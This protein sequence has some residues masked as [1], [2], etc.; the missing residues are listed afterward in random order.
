MLRCCVG[1]GERV[2]DGEMNN[3]GEKMAFVVEV[4]IKVD[5]LI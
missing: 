5:H 2:D 3:N 1:F 4:K